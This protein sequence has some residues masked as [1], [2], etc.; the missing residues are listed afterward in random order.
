RQVAPPAIEASTFHPF[1][2]VAAEPRWATLPALRA[3]RRGD[4]QALLL[5][6]PAGRAALSP[7]T[8]WDT[9]LLTG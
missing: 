4:S 6:R 5:S 3:N 2:L 8:A 9:I 7:T 1:L